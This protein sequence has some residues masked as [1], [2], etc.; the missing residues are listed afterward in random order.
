MK[1]AEPRSSV[2]PAL[3]CLPQK[4]LLRQGL[5]LGCCGM[6]KS[7][8]KQPI[9]AE[10]AVLERVVLLKLEFSSLSDSYVWSSSG[11]ED[12][13]QMAREGKPSPEHGWPP[14]TDTPPSSS[15]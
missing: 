14:L 7:F 15:E 6:W 13:G 11:P 2:N 10:V 3:C 8:K 4:L 5:F 12:T 1:P 9:S